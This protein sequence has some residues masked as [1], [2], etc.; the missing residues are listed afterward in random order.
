MIAEFCK[1][2]HPVE[3]SSYTVLHTWCVRYYLVFFNWNKLAKKSVDK[4]ARL[5]VSHEE[6]HLNINPFRGRRYWH[7][8]YVLSVGKIHFA[9]ISIKHGNFFDFYKK[10]D[11]I[12]CILMLSY[13]NLISTVQSAPFDKMYG[14]KVLHLKDNFN[15]TLIIKIVPS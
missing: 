8:L 1:K 6:S 5:S 2:L 3:K 12:F 13:I 7:W 4:N 15:I 11:Y 9:R 10:D 14:K